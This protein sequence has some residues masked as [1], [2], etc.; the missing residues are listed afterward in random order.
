MITE[1]EIEMI[2]EQQEQRVY[3]SIKL[4]TELATQTD[5]TSDEYQSK[6]FTL[7][8]LKK[9]ISETRTDLK[10]RIKKFQDSLEN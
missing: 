9:E 1:K 4:A 2:Q 8:S 10:N 5:R 3:Q 6:L 7:E